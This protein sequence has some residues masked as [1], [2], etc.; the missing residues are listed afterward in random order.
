MVRVGDY[1]IVKSSE[2]MIKSRGK[3]KAGVVNDLFDFCGMIG[4]ITKL[5]EYDCFELD[6]DNGS[7]W[8]DESLVTV[9][10]KS[11]GLSKYT[12]IELLEELKK[13]VN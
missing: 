11:N 9:I 8:W 6:I 5:R 7:W 3:S 13:R 12:S 1:V 2:E 4:K 10:P